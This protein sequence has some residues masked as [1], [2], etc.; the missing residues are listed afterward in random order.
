MYVTS[1]MNPLHLNHHSH[2]G[3]AVLAL[4]SDWSHWEQPHHT[5]VTR[6]IAPERTPQLKAQAVPTV[7]TATWSPLFPWF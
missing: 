5:R 7:A 1:W 4:S 3:V 6:S 2:Q